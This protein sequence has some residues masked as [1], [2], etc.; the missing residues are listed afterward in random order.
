MRIA[1]AISGNENILYPALAALISVKKHN[2]NFDLYIISSK[3]DADE[4]FLHYCQLN[5]INYIVTNYEMDCFLGKF[6]SFSRYPKEIFLRYYLIKY[7]SDKDYDFFVSMDYDCYCVDE[8]KLNELLPFNEFI[9]YKPVNNYYK[10]L[11]TSDKPTILDLINFEQSINNNISYPHGGFLVFNLKNFSN[12]NI[13]HE[14]GN[15]YKSLHKLSK[16][17]YIPLDEHI[18]SSLLIKLNLPVKYLNSTYNASNLYNFTE[19]IKNLHFFFVKPWHSIEQ[20][21]EQVHKRR[22]LN[23]IMYLVHISEYIDFISD[24]PFANKILTNNITKSDI[25]RLIH[26]LETEYRNGTLK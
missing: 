7:F 15:L 26:N 3:N 20:I 6:S 14:F 12:I 17:H 25:F 9:A 5:D 4:E 8:Y 19:N 16:A 24:F 2:K 23:S 22:D 18:L 11:N 21:N 1:C 13:P 10:T